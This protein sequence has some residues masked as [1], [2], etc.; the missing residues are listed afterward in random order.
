[1]LIKKSCSITVL[2]LIVALVIA[3]VACVKTPDTI[4]HIAHADGSLSEFSVNWDGTYTNA[5]GDAI[6]TD[7][8]ATYTDGSGNEVSLDITGLPEASSDAGIYILTVVVEGDVALKNTTHLYEIR[9]REVTVDWRGTY[10]SK[11]GEAIADDIEAYFTDKDGQIVQAV[12]TGF[13]QA[14]AAAGG[15]VLKATVDNNNYKFINGEKAYIIK[16]DHS[17]TVISGLQEQI[18]SLNG[19]I[20]DLTA[21]LNTAIKANAELQTALT[22]QQAQIDNSI[23]ENAALK[24]TNRGQL[25]ATIVLAVIS[26]ICMVAIGVYI[27]FPLRRKPRQSKAVACGQEGEKFPADGAIASCENDRY[28]RVGHKINIL[29]NTLRDIRVE[30]EFNYNEKGL[31]YNFQKLDEVLRRMKEDIDNMISELP[32]YIPE[33]EVRYDSIKMEEDTSLG[34][35]NGG[36]AEVM[37]AGK[38]CGD[39]VVRKALVRRCTDKENP[40]NE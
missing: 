8:S 20:G 40:G 5:Y 4:D 36:V 7:I 25:A 13:P 17:D 31:Q 16:D 27:I 18:N 1:M 38:R 19:S 6:A 12:V 32:D 35:G 15:Y 39:T 29:I 11:L 2:L 23:A 9:Q 22:A 26:A 24:R 34:Y 28:T 37:R 10:E 30:A 21:Q 33:E 14:G 3:G